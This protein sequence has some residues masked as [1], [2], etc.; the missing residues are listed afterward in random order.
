MLYGRAGGQ[1][2]IRE[3][4]SRPSFLDDE[5]RRL[6]M[7]TIKKERGES[8]RM[9]QE[10][11]EELRRLAS[12]NEALKKEIG[13]SF[14]TPPERSS[15][16]DS[17]GKGDKGGDKKRR[18]KSI[19]DGSV[20]QQDQRKKG[21]GGAAGGAETSLQGIPED[22]TGV[23]GALTVT[24]N[25]QSM[26]FMTLML[27]SMKELQKK[28][29]DGSEEKGQVGGV[30]V[31]RAGAP[32]L[33]TLQPWTSTHGPLQLGD[34]LSLIEP[35]VSDL[36][37]TS[38]QWWVLMMSEVEMWYQ[39]HMSLGPLERIEH[40]A[41]TPKCLQL[42]KWQRLERRVATMV[43][44]AIPEVHRE[45]L[46]SSRRLSVYGI[47]T[48]LFVMFCPGGLQEKQTLLK[49]LEDPPE[50][51]SASE[52]ATS[53]RR[54]L[55][56]RVRARE[57]GAIEPDSSILAKGLTKITRR[58]LEGNRE[59]SFRVALARN[60]LKVDVCPTSSTV[61]QYATHLLA[62]FEQAAQ[63]DKRAA[64]KTEANPPKVKKFEEEGP[65]AK[66]GGKSKEEAREPLK[67]TPQK[68]RFFL[69]EHGCRKGKECGWSHDQSDDKR[70]C[71]KC[72]SPSHLSPSCPTSST[73]TAK[74]KTSKKEEAERGEKGKKAEE[75]EGVNE[76]P[77]SDE[78]M[79]G[80]LEEAN[81][82]LKTLSIKPE[83]EAPTE[84]ISSLQAQ[85]DEL[86]KHPKL[87][88]LRITRLAKIGGGGDVGLLDSG[89]THPL[90]PITHV[91]DLQRLQ[92]VQVALAD[93][94]KAS[95]LM[96]KGGTMVSTDLE[97]E[98]IVP[99]GLLTELGC[100]IHWKEGNLRVWHPCRGQLPVS[101]VHGC[102]QIPR[103]LAL[104]LIGELEE[105]RLIGGLRKMVKEVE[106]LRREEVRKKEAAWLKEVAE[107]HPLF[108][109]LPDHVKR[110]LV[111]EP[112][113]MSDLPAN[114]HQRKRLKDGFI[115][116]LFAGS[117]EGFTLYRAMKELGCQ[118]KLLEVDVLR[119]KEHDFGG[120]SKVYKGLLRAALHNI[121]K[122]IVGGP[123]C[124]SR[125]VLRH[126]P[127]PG[128]PRPV[129]AWGGEEFGLQ[130]LT[131]TEREMVEGDDALMWR[132]FFLHTVSTFA[133]KA[134]K[135]KAFLVEQP[136]EPEYM[137]EVVSLW[138]TKE[139]KQIREFFDWK[140]Q[141]FAQGDYSNEEEAVKPTKVAGNMDI[142]LPTQKNPYA[143][144]R[145]GGQ[146]DSKQ[147]ARW[148][149][150]LMRAVALS[151]KRFLD[152]EM[153][154]GGL[155]KVK[156]LS[157]QDHVRCGHVP[158][159]RDCRV[160]QESSAKSKPHRRVRSK[161][162]GVLSADVTGPLKPGE[163]HEGEQKY[164]LVGTFTWPKRPNSEEDPLE[165]DDEPPDLKLEDEEREDEEG[166]ENKEEEERGEQGLTLED[167]NM[168]YKEIFGED[169]TPSEES[170]GEVK[171]GR[172]DGFE[173]VEM[174][175]FR[176]AVP[177]PAKTAREVLAGVA[178]MYLQLR[179]HGYTVKQLH[180]DRGSEFMSK[181]MKSW[182]LTHDIYKTTTAGDSSESNGRAERAIQQVKAEVRRLLH[183]KGWDYTRWPLACHYVN[184]MQR[185]RMSDETRPIPP[186]GSEVLVKKRDWHTKE[187]LPTHEK[188][189]Y[190]APMPEYHGLW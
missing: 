47:I 83:S 10:F 134:T 3:S 36:S 161:I 103:S 152:G 34:W 149:P 89:A 76:V 74:V 75:V 5:E 124:R 6:F 178:Q 15:G 171:E 71:Y 18:M 174:D 65:K 73:S 166:D 112:G 117:E 186:F 121:L 26:Q 118:K 85:L 24:L 172:G 114:R 111:M 81:R 39:D 90:R 122:G 137:E 155:V 20:D 95:L 145:G 132:M 167:R 138:R 88:T 60:Q 82:M 190:I 135:K 181:M 30:E 37:T 173:N 113:E 33:P 153:E 2:L 162:G 158:F 59:L 1:G 44:K 12:E 66:G 9:R 80:L 17:G 22:Q 42:K 29:G 143:R 23:P 70:R 130:Q 107:E 116:H 141:S 55:R 119:G 176:M 16:D 147:L 79:V 120:E 51:G 50:A 8:L 170:E 86:R 19:E 41:E 104:Q 97:V 100:S 38:E 164:I 57:V 160:C 31:V 7:E 52:V 179:I 68:C 102:P 21:K 123:P 184:Q 157:W 53:L 27:E 140:E 4:R 126:Y 182:C 144:G 35:V 180:T 159:R 127:K 11:Q 49:N 77:K 148:R 56:W 63:A 110:A 43:L 69:T 64:Q 142:Q 98:P 13:E 92:P 48:H 129:R 87:K 78:A 46:V 115:C 185:R 40:S 136:K 62:E 67:E 61:T 94:T 187:L 150:G 177:L 156:A 139:W 25:Q 131:G 175:V 105:D 99:M 101:L 163:D 91:E 32:E 96:T 58:V 125:S 168:I 183:A 54:W 28:I 151:L 189:T 72:G 154:D 188:V 109:D 106:D 146:Q 93:G 128:G 84:K 108:R 169:V 165:K 133:G 45:E 14:Y